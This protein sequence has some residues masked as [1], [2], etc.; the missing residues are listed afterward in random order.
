D[1]RFWGDLT[2]KLAEAALVQADIT[3][4]KNMVPFDSRSPM[5][6]SGIR[7]GTPALTTRG[8]RAEHMEQVATWIDQVLMAPSDETLIA[9]VRAEVNAFMSAFPMFQW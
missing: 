8:L 6:T 1:R 9:R 3:A 4:N 5:V 2:G 7:L